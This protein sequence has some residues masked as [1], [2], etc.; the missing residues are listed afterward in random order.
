MLFT[1]KGSKVLR[2]DISSRRKRKYRQQRAPSSQSPST[3]KPPSQ[4]E[5]TANNSISTL[6]SKESLPS[7]SEEATIVLSS[8]S[9]ESKESIITFDDKKSRRIAIAFQFNTLL[10]APPKAQWTPA[11]KLICENLRIKTM[12]LDQMFAIFEQCILCNKNNI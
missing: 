7:E 3:P 1:K 2:F 4:P 5:L 10:G 8:D 9:E 12:R 6:I 11:A